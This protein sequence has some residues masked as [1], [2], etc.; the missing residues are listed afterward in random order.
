MAPGDAAPAGRLRLRL[1]RCLL[2]PSLAGWP[3]GDSDGLVALELEHRQGRITALRPLPTATGPLPLALTPLVEPHAHLDKCFTAEAYP[4][5]S[6]HPGRCPGPEPAGG[7]NAQPG[8][9][10]AAGRGGSGA[11]LA[12]W[13]AGHAQPH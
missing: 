3:V 9:G 11:G 13:F 2:D 4:N 6:R 10:A 8:A 1:P 12:P 7:G 5:R